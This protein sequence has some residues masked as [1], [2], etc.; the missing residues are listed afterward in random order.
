VSTW[1]RV[2]FRERCGNCGVR[3]LRGEP[4]LL[5]QGKPPDTWKS[6]RCSLF[7]CCG[8]AIPEDLPALVDHVVLGPMPLVQVGPDLLPLDYKTRQGGE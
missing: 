7:T 2:A 4:A 6:Y 8:Q 5:F 3:I 1:V